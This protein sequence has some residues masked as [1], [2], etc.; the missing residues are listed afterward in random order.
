VAA[1][2]N[3]RGLCEPGGHVIGATPVLIGI[4]ELPQWGMLDY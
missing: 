3:L 2:A 4:H 1:A